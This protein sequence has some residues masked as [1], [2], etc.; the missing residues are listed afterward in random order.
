MSSAYDIYNPAIPKNPE[1]RARL[2]KFFALVTLEP[3][4]Y[5][6]EMKKAW[7]DLADH[8]LLQSFLKA[9]DNVRVMVADLID[10][11]MP[12]SL[13]EDYIHRK[14]DIRITYSE[15]EVLYPLMKQEMLK[16]FR[17]SSYCHMLT[18][19]DAKDA[20]NMVVRYLATPCTFKPRRDLS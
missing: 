8:V 12:K 18:G 7:V 11:V 20:E 5:L 2:E 19:G 3:D 17:E 10:D 4:P 6:E 15:D 1:D 13:A 16:Q 9:R 14:A